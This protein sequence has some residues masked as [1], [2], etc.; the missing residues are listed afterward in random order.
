MNHSNNISRDSSNQTI[1]STNNHEESSFMDNASTQSFP[2]TNSSSYRILRN[3]RIQRRIRHD[4][5]TYTLMNNQ[6]ANQLLNGS[7]FF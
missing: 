6:F 7:N 3:R 5:N 4:G 1:Y 2:M